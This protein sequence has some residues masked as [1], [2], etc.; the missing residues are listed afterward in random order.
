VRVTQ[1]QA[2]FHGGIQGAVGSVVAHYYQQS[3]GQ[4][5]HVDVSIQEA[6]MLALMSFAETWDILRINTK[7]QGPFIIRARPQPLGT[8]LLRQVYA[9]K[10]GFVT[11]YILGGA[12]AGITL[13][14]RALTEWANSLGYALEIKDYDW[15]KLD[16]GTMPQSE[17]NR[18][19]DALSPFLLTR[20]KAEIMKESVERAI[21][22]F[23][24]TDAKD[25]V[26]SPQFKAREF[27]VQV[28]HPELGDTI[29]YPG[30]PVKVTG[31]PYT[32]QRRAPLI[33]EHNEEVY[34]GELGFSREELT[35]LKARGVI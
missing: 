22:F 15:T 11:G 24:V 12:Q 29:T 27:F 28:E 31:F 4:G 21:I 35:A 13:S 6:V 19:E 5:Q 34:I 25:I 26:E 17:F 9:S 10:D 14:S 18:V 32:P 1:P 7:R 2:F 16:T 33:G 20:A 3:T 30:F 8:V 23:S